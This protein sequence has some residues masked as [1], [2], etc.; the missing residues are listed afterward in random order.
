MNLTDGK[1]AGVR[2]RR[3]LILMPVSRTKQPLLRAFGHVLGVLHL[4]FEQSRQ[5]AY[6]HA[7]IAR[8]VRERAPSLRLA[9]GGPTLWRWEEGQVNRTDPLVLEELAGLYG[10][11]YASL[12]AVLRA[13]RADPTLSPEDGLKIL[14]GVSDAS[15][16][17]TPS[18]RSD[19]ATVLNVEYVAEIAAR[20]IDSGDTLH[21]LAEE[22]LGRQVAALG[23]PPT[24]RDARDRTSRG[25]TPRHN[26]NPRRGA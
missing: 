6:S 23:D 3:A 20:L 7:A 8:F 2:W 26:S 21:Q 1:R 9:F 5:R 13:N 4:K 11:D 24:G 14:E 16:T 17:K 22:I 15:H 10:T 25:Q 19:A 18:D 12:S